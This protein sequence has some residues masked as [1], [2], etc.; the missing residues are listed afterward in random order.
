MFITINKYSTN[1]IN[2]KI[3]SLLEMK[4]NV[5]GYSFF[6]FF[7]F[8]NILA[9]FLKFGPVV[10]L[11]NLKIWFNIISFLVNYYSVEIISSV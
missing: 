4:I 5:S 9:N 8:K 10:Y 11:S 3:F 6:T 2:Y 1:C 7:V